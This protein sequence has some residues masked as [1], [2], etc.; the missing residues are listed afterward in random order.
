[1]DHG[2]QQKQ[3]GPY[4]QEIFVLRKDRLEYGSIAEVSDAHDRTFFCQKCH[5]QCQKFAKRRTLSSKVISTMCTSST[6]VSRIAQRARLQLWHLEAHRLM[7]DDPL[8]RERR[9]KQ[10]RHEQEMSSQEADIQVAKMKRVGILR[11][12]AKEFKDKLAL[13]E[14]RF[15]PDLCPPITANSPS[16]PFGR[17]LMESSD[18]S[19][20]VLS[21]PSGNPGITAISLSGCPGQVPLSLSG[22]PG[23]TST[24][25]SSLLERI[26]TSPSGSSGQP[27]QET[28]YET[29]AGSNQDLRSTGKLA[30]PYVLV[31]E[32]APRIPDLPHGSG[33]VT[34][35]RAGPHVDRVGATLQNEAPR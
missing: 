5:K 16:V 25:P 30:L 21:D 33:N 15:V 31:G 8:E 34:A 24:V 4:C 6:F 3:V 11:K 14:R 28:E 23:E 7:E 20:Q 12:Q 19:E 18:I 27:R 35:D 2:T 10:L 1:M 26:S 22:K 32:V 13:E 29:D 9:G 17:K